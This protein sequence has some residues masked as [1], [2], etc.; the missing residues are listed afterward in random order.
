MRN[1]FD[2]DDAQFYVL[3]NEEGEHSLWPVFASV[4][5]GWTIAH[6]PN[7][8]QACLDYVESHWTDMR[9]QSLVDSMSSEAN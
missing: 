1:P 9:P 5:S 3:V 8:R 6:G 2:D 7:A 4:P